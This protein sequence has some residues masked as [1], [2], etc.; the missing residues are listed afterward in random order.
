MPL[1]DVASVIT[2]AADSHMTRAL[3]ERGARLQQ[4]G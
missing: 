1:A 3:V 2:D 4:V